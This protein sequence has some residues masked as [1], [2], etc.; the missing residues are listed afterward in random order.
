MYYQLLKHLSVIILLLSVAACATPP[1]QVATKPIDKI[2][3]RPSDPTPVTML[4][5][6]FKIVTAATAPA[7]I[8]NL[9]KLQ[10][11]DTSFL[12]I[13]LSDYENMALN[14]ADLKRYILSEKAII[15]Y[16]RDATAPID[17]GKKSDKP[18]NDSTPL[19]ISKNK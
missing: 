6:N 10:G 13:T 14:L 5:M 7:V 1:I 18:T 11:G 19:Q 3:A 9:T 2:I 4:P 16:Y 15:E 17:T 8:Q 12:I